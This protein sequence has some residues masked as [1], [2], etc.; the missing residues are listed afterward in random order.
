MMT[1]TEACD[2]KQRIGDPVE[3]LTVKRELASIVADRD[4]LQF[5]ERDGVK[6]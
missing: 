2:D 5:K 1:R 4:D 6:T 3:Y